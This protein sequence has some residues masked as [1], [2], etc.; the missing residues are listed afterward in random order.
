MRV[1][2]NGQ[3]N[4][5]LKNGQAKTHDKPISNVSPLPREIPSHHIALKE[6][7]TELNSLVGKFTHGFM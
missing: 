4:V 2:N 5:V 6:I 3:I 1:R 7:E